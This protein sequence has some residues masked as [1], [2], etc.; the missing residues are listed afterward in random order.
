M[1]FGMSIK[2]TVQTLVHNWITF[3]MMIVLMLIVL[4]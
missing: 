3:V 1:K 4:L 2:M